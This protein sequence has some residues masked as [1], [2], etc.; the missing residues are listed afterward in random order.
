MRFPWKKK[1]AKIEVG[2]ASTNTSTG[3]TRISNKHT[4][5]ISNLK[6]EYA[7]LDLKALEYTQDEDLCGD[8]KQELNR[9]IK[10]MVEIKYEIGIRESLTRS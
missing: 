7:E 8:E 4:I 9:I 6:V 2:I 5:R 3:I 10:R 1:K